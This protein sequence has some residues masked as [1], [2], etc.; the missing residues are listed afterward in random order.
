VRP[1]VDSGFRT[2][3]CLKTLRD[4]S[5]DAGYESVD[6][7]RDVNFSEQTRVVIVTGVKENLVDMR[8]PDFFDWITGL[9]DDPGL[10]STV[11]KMVRLYPRG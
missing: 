10:N 1:H 8:Q 7:L 4:P 2:L 3:N 6:R 11:G 5:R 9:P